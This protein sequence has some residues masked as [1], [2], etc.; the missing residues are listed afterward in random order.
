MARNFSR[1][2]L[3]YHNRA[4]FPATRDRWLDRHVEFC[5]SESSRLRSGTIGGHLLKYVFAHYDLF[6]ATGRR[7][8]RFKTWEAIQAACEWLAQLEAGGRS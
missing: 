8:E 5:G 6:K 2:E 7:S 1:N 3:I 4:D